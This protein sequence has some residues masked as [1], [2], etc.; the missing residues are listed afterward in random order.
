LRLDQHG[1]GEM[2]IRVGIIGTGVMGADHAKALCGHVPGAFLKSVYDADAARARQIADQTGAETVATSPTAL[3][4]DSAI[5]AVLIAS[6]DSTH[7]ELAL[8]CLAARKPVLC[9]KPLA[10]TP[11]ECLEV[12]AAE[13]KLGKRLVQVGYMRRFDPSYVDMK[14]ACAFGQLGKALMLHC[15][16]RNVSAPSWFD[17]KMAVTNSAVHEFDIAR[18]LLDD[19]MASV[20]A[21]M[22][23]APQISTGSPVFLVLSTARGR[24]VTIEV[25]VNAGYGYE[26]RGEL[27]C[28]QG[29]LALREPA[30][31]ET[32]AAFARSIAYPAD[33]RPRFADAYRLQLQSWIQS[34]HAGPGR[35]ANAWDGYAASAV[36]EAGLISLAGACEIKIELAEK[37]RLYE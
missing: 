26:V 7:K 11:A 14:A 37:P 18:W 27:V 31:I 19:E 9:E 1:E 24:L 33:W 29:T 35:G 13:A 8:S 32:N 6:P 10:P 36:A 30:L 15:L 2:A 12:T 21:Y 4:Q 25:F 3:I 5:D 16:H 20:R 34:I 22:P 17:A 23:G 28:E